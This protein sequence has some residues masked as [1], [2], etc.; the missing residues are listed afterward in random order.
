MNTV[1]R[2]NGGLMPVALP[3]VAPLQSLRL[4]ILAI[5]SAFVVVLALVFAL[6]TVD[7]FRGSTEINIRHEGMM[8]SNMIEAS[9]EDLA[10]R[11]DVSGMQAY[12]DRLVAIREK[13]DI[14]MNIL[15]LRGDYSEV[16]A[17]N[18]PDNIE[19][20]DPEEHEELM[21]ALVRERPTIA[22]ELEDADFDDDDDPGTYA[23][24]NHPDYYMPLGYRI[25]SIMTPLTA[26]ERRVGAV[27]VKMSL[28]FL[29]K[30]LAAIHRNIALAVC[31]GLVLLIAGLVSFLNLR[32][33]RPLWQI[34]DRVYRFGVGEVKTPLPEVKRRDEIGVLIDEFNTMVNRINRVES[35]NR[36]YQDQLKELV[37]ER[38][39]ELEATQ[40]ATILS[41]AS[42][43]EYRDPETGGHIKRTQNYIKALAGSLR[44]HPRFNEY[45]DD[46]TIELLYKSAPLHDIGKVG[47]RD[48]ILLKPGALSEQEFAEMQNHT[49]FGRNAIAATET[50]LGTNSFLRFAKEIAYSHQEKWDG[51][52]YPEGLSGEDIPI[53]GRL[54][55]VADVYDALISRR[56]YKP[57]FRH[58]AAVEIIA[59]GRGKHFDPDMVDAFVDL[60]ETFRD[61]AIE[62]AESDEERLAVL[63]T[64]VMVG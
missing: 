6:Y 24:P 46:E 48:E 21:N 42:L 37:L 3:R 54:M 57:P 2:F 15:L 22:V 55:A 63:P 58:E 49:I 61:I 1:V 32:L 17:S 9:I 12:L 14:E 7:Q 10:S 13:N 51:S 25:I 28:A 27:N 47:I 16:V 52:G 44:E 11:E 40:E 20:A 33:F 31:G 34:A 41:M 45:L 64:H 35:R 38:T 43:A 5:V 36:Q 39:S 50:K 60:S 8:L 18:I 23:D 62:F 4:R 56:C 26:G 59:E 30:K 53:S 29:D 19:A